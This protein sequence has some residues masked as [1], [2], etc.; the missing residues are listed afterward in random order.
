SSPANE[1]LAIAGLA[2]LSDQVKR[3]KVKDALMLANHPARKGI[4]SP[5]E[6]RAWRDA[7]SA[8][9]RIAVG[10]EG[11]PGHQAGGLPSPLGPGGA[12]GI[13]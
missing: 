7:T 6:I 9:H 3:R 1:A 2:F 12:R 4:D 5:H 10:M 13:Y 11:A 8:S